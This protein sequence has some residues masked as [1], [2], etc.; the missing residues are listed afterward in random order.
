MGF[1]SRP[2]SPITSAF[3]VRR[4]A[5][6]RPFPSVH[7][8][9]ERL[10]EAVQIVD[11][12]LTQRPAEVGARNAE[13]GT[14]LRDSDFRVPRSAFGRVGSQYLPFHLP[15]ASEITPIRLLGET[16]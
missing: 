2:S 15:D 6:G 12:M 1:R 16:V 5:F 8:R 11:R 3:R 4:S 10:E 13:R 14:D 9:M 7:E